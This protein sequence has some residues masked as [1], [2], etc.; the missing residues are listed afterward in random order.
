MRNRDEVALGPQYEGSRVSRKV[1]ED[2]SDGLPESDYEDAQESLEPE[3]FAD[4]DTMDMVVDWEEGEID[5]D[6][7]FGDSDA[8]KVKDFAFRGVKEANGVSRKRKTAADFMTDSEEEKSDAVARDNGRL[9]DAKDI[10]SGSERSDGDREANVSDNESDIQENNKVDGRLSPEPETDEDD[11][12]EEE[13]SGSDDDDDIQDD[14]ERTTRAELRKIMGEEQKSVVATISQAAK[15]D[16]EKGGAVKLQRKTFDSLLNIRIRLQKALVATNSMASTLENEDDVMPPYQAAEGAAI[17]LL[18]TLDTLRLALQGTG[19]SL[20]AGTKRKR[21]VGVNTPDAIIW[22]QMESLEATA[23]PK[24]QATLEKW[25][26]KVKNTTAQPI[27]RTLNNTVAQQ[28]IIDVL[29]DQLLNKERLIRRTKM[30]RS[31]APV[32]TKMKVTEDPNIYD[33]ADFYQLLLKELVDQRMIDFYATSTQAGW[34]G[35]SISQLTAVKEAKTKKNVDTKASKGR[36]LRYTVHEKLQNF[37]APVDV[38]TW[39]Q[40]AVDRLFGT[41]LGQRTDLGE[42]DGNKSDDGGDDVPLAE[43]ALLLFRS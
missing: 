18:N 13:S 19:N 1:L 8:E 42:E 26:A 41:L 36:K 2:D 37:M 15:A 32:Q 22:Q 11:E 6:E 24:R 20:R 28:T 40:D 10:R 21:P 23:I 35:E 27:S 33:D 16:A 3:Q 5:S 43:E 39:E 14:K 12:D 29:N 4:P 9:H 31:C 7:A 17:K 34:S 38:G 25:S 30:P